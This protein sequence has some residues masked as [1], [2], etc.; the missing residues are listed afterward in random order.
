MNMDIR[1]LRNLAS[2]LAADGHISAK[3]VRK[4]AQAA[5]EGPEATKNL[6]KIRDQFMAVFSGADSDEM[7]KLL[8]SPAPSTEKTKISA[9]TH[10]AVMSTFYGVR[11]NMGEMLPSL[12]VGNRF[13]EERLFS[14]KRPN[15]FHYSAMIPV[16]ATGPEAAKADPN[17]AT[18]CY[19]KVTGGAA[20]VTSYY[21]PFEIQ[22]GKAPKEVRIMDGDNGKTIKVKKGQDVVVFLNT[23]PRAGES[24]N[25]VYTDRSLAYPADE[26]YIPRYTGPSMCESPGMMRFTW[27]TN[28]PYITKGSTHFVQMVLGSDHNKEI[29][30]FN[31]K[32]EIE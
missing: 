13:A 2:E 15:G 30:N 17:K 28:N 1:G 26:T 20:G 12:P 4:L 18:S 11:D 25:V 32:L 7:R 6:K 23:N 9:A 14:E 5:G 21:G 29:R 27:K 19:F 10:K 3:D 22:R 24:W 31:F 16:G 8:G